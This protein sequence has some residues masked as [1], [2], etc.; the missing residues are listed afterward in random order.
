[1]PANESALLARQGDC[2]QPTLE[3]LQSGHAV[4]EDPEGVAAHRA[5][6][7]LVSRALTHDTSL[8]PSAELVFQKHKLAPHD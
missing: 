7:L 3:R 1:M 8:R 6:P 5:R 2:L 4:E